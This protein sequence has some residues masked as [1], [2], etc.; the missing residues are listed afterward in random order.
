M[1]ALCRHSHIKVSEEKGAGKRLDIFLKEAFSQFSRS[2]FQKLISQ[3]NI[4]VNGRREKPSYLLKAGDVIDVSFPLSKEIIPVPE[5][6]PLDIIF[7]DDAIIVINKPAGMIVHPVRSGQKGTIVN[8]LLHYSSRL[9]SVG[10]PLRPGIVHRLDKDTSGL[11]V[12]AKDD[13]THIALSMQ[14]KKREVKKK[15]LALV[16]GVPSQKEGIIDFKIGRHKRLWGKME[17]NGKLAL[18]LIHI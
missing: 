14:F 5:P 4:T 15:Y 3:G 7:E 9:S 6:I 12:V 8:A 18:S 10:G 1:E 16:R 13:L 17:K 2:Y 11:M